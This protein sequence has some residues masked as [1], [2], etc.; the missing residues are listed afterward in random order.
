MPEP[1]QTPTTQNQPGLSAVTA[2]VPPS[3][4]NSRRRRTFPGRLFYQPLR[5][6]SG[7]PAGSSTPARLPLSFSAAPS[8][9]RPDT[10]EA[11]AT[12]EP[13]QPIVSG[14]G[15]GLLRAH[16]MLLAAP[17]S[18]LPGWGHSPPGHGPGREF[19][20]CRSPSPR[21]VLSTPGP[22]L[23]ALGRCHPS[24]GEAR[25]SEPCGP[26]QWPR[27]RLPGCAGARRLRKRS[28]GLRR[29]P[30]RLPRGLHGFKGCFWSRCF[31]GC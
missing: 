5:G 24:V 15:C 25:Q 21:D 14:C 17:E 28:E 7:Y 26:A 27:P 23:D 29:A 18:P 30:C 10:M 13:G 6:K 3:L 31:R 22:G 19:F 8:P 20:A 16:G 11:M 9:P 12:L 4:P 1:G 2:A